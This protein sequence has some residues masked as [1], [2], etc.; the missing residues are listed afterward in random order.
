MVPVIAIDGPSGS[1]KGTVTER[2]AAR[3]GWRV[4]DSGALYRLV[5]QAAA[6]TGANFDNE[7]EINNISR[8]GFL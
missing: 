6:S 7:I 1:G 5:G 4:L 2:V 3:L 8:S